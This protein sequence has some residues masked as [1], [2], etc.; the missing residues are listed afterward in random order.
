MCWN[1]LNDCMQTRVPLE[2]RPEVVACAAIFLVCR[3]MRIKLPLSPPWYS[4]FGCTLRDLELV[5][6]SL[7]QL[8]GAS[9]CGTHYVLNDNADDGDGDAAMLDA[10]EYLMF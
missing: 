5:C 2:H 7:A 4:L 8:Y 1:T 6:A 3:L 10:S 9:S